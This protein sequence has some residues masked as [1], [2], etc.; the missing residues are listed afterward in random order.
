MGD[1]RID[2]STLRN[3]YPECDE[4]KGICGEQ[5]KPEVLPQ[6]SRDLSEDQS[7]VGGSDWHAPMLPDPK[8]TQLAQVAKNM[9]ATKP[10]TDSELRATYEKMS[11]AELEK[12][13]TTLG[14]RLSDGGRYPDADLDTRKFHAAEAVAK[15]RADAARPKEK[16]VIEGT[17]H[18]FPNVDEAMHRGKDLTFGHVTTEWVPGHGGTSVTAVHG[19]HTWHVGKVDLSASGDAGSLAMD[20]GIHNVDGSTGFHTSGGGTLAGVEGTIHKE[21]LGSVTVGF[22][23]GASA[24]ASAG[25]KK[26]GTRAEVCGRVGWEIFTVG[27][28]LPLPGRW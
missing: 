10:P 28:C 4:E 6:Y 3:P 26:E 13:V 19:Q 17:K 20:E 25:L 22:S 27:A 5:K 12:E 16:E 1:T 8:P 18:L 15:S 2:G 14:K 7:H 9:S 21:G 11:D 23:A 24:E